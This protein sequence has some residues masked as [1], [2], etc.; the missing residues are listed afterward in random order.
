MHNPVLKVSPWLDPLR[1]GIM[2]GI[3]ARE[4]HEVFQQCITRP[5]QIPTSAAALKPPGTTRK[6]SVED[7]SKRRTTTGGGEAV[8][9]ELSSIELHF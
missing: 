8:G 9:A 2:E 7:A 4:H 3:S 5:F 1:R 6:Q